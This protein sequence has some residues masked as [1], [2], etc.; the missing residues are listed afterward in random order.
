MQVKCILSW[1]GRTSKVGMYD[2]FS[3]I[4]TDNVLLLALKEFL[5]L[6]QPNNLLNIHL[7]SHFQKI[8]SCVVGGQSH[9]ELQNI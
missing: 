3:T 2:H 1:E 7:I 4:P 6:R 9:K 8:K 5:R